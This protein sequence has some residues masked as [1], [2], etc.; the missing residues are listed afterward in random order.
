M[1]NATI[2]TD[3]D[4]VKL[5]AIRGVFIQNFK[6]QFF[7]RASKSMPTPITIESLISTTETRIQF[8]ANSYSLENKFVFFSTVQRGYFFD[9]N[10]WQLISM[11]AIHQE[12][13]K[14]LKGF[15]SSVPLPQKISDAKTENKAKNMGDLLR[16]QFPKWKKETS[17]FNL[18][19]G[20]DEKM[21]L[22]QP[23]RHCLKELLRS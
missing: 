6:S 19:T 11:T 4:G 2:I 13:G 1:D 17:V 21:W 10:L 5:E 23:L 18:L 7:N 20:E 22:Q 12:S 8:I 9:G 16:E 14:T 3:C 15:T